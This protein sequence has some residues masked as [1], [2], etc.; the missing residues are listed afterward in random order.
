MIRKFIPTDAANCCSLIH[1][2]IELDATIP[3]I[4]RGE[5]VQSET[6][7]TMLERSRL[8]YVAVYE[9]DGIVLGL[10]GLDMNEIRIL[11]VSPTHQRSGIGR[12]LLDHLISM[13]PKFLFPDVF[14]YAF[15]EAVPFYKTA[16]FIEKGPVVYKF[17]G[18]KLRTVFMILPIRQNES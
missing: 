15:T 11:C 18:G 17:A 16:G 6:P 3:G 1:A 4:L 2:C 12:A 8:F 10:A 5:M 13:V 7:H 14:V 9:S